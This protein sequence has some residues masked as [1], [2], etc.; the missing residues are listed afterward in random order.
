MLALCAW[1]QRFKRLV[2]INN[3]FY[4]WRWTAWLCLTAQLM[5]LISAAKE[6]N[7]EFVYAISPGLDITF[8]NPKEVTAL[9]RKLSQ[10][11]PLEDN[12]TS[13]LLLLVFNHLFCTACRWAGSAAGRS[14]CCLTTSRQKCVRLI[15]RCLARL[16]KLRCPSLTRCFCTWRSHTPSSSAPPVNTGSPR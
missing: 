8:S 10:V 5:T 16:L 7:V 4:F 3:V 13:H 1:I 12:H 15:K 11:R 6:H 2:C 9:K 14:R